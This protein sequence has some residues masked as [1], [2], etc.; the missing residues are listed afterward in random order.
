M[1]CADCK[2]VM[3]LLSESHCI[4]SMASGRICICT[5]RVKGL[6]IQMHWAAYFCC[7][8]LLQCVC[9]WDS[10]FCWKLSCKLVQH[11]SVHVWIEE[12]PILSYSVSYVGTKQCLE[13][14]CILWGTRMVVPSC[15][16]SQI[17]ERSQLKPLSGK[18]VPSCMSSGPTYTERWRTKWSPSVRPIKGWF[19]HH[20]PRGADCI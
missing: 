10:V 1:I 20:M 18:A 16:W 12:D 2:C 19:H 4:L 9:P 7:T 11:S 3:S 8:H 14:G 6:Q 15:D 5:E 13:D 17:M